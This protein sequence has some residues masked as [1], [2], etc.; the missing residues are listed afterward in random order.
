MNSTTLTAVILAL[1]VASATADLLPTHRTKVKFGN[2]EVELKFSYAGADR[3]AQLWDESEAATTPA[4]QERVWRMRWE[5]MGEGTAL[6]SLASHEEQRGNFV[7][8]Y[9]HLYAADRIA[10]WY[11]AS[12]KTK[13]AQGWQP[14]GPVMQS[15]FDEVEADMNRV[16]EKLTPSQRAQGIK[17]AAQI[18]RDN[19]NCCAW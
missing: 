8:A 11:T 1:T 5:E 13:S 19:P 6:Q 15:F 17:L 3:A 7:S 16:G 2:E 9:A 12:V 10:K 14:V 4:E 18:I